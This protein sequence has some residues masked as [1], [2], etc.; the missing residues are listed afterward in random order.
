MSDPA[1]DGMTDD[2]HGPGWWVGSDGYWH[3]PDE[4]FDADVPKRNHP[5]RRVA[6]V[7]LAVALVG[8]TTVGAWLGGASGG[9]G[10]VSAGPPLA[11]L[12][13][14][15]EHVVVGAG[16]HEFGVTGVTGV[17]CG[18]VVSWRPGSTFRCTVYASSQRKIGVYEGTVESAPSSEEWRWRGAWYPVLGRS[19][20]E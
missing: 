12:E 3:S 17:T 7:L 16:A 13:A 11:E 8:A 4:E 10:P 5:A 19:T 18:P 14:Q 2:L 20:T 1:M 9:V 6:V 15:V